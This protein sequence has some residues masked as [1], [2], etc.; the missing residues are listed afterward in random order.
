MG[1]SSPALKFRAMINR[2]VDSRWDNHF[3]KKPHAS[4]E[5]YLA[6]FEEAR[7][8][9]YPQIDELEAELG[10]AIDRLWL[11]ELAL[12]TQIVKKK[13][14]L[15]YPHGRLLYSLLRRMIAELGLDFV[16]ILE[17]GTA[18]GFSAVCMAKALEDAK[19]DGWIVTVDVLSHQRSQIWNCI[20]DHDGPKSRA[21]LLEP[22]SKLTRKIVFMQGDT[23]HLLP[24]IGMGRVHFA[25]LDNQ[26]TAES[27]MQEFGIVSSMQQSG[28]II[29]F[30]DVTPMVFPGV[31][32]AVDKIE[33]RKDYQV[34]RMTLSHQRAYAWA[35]R[36]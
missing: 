10:Y 18:R 21:S 11:D 3:G 32:A 9:Q 1:L 34:R 4:R 22:W 20:D 36:S 12:H 24:R 33:T 19:V 35:Q 29:V 27:V 6:L 16:S 25:F 2:W 7:L 26:H 17:T 14:E 30:D 5:D 31:V 8:K 15:A 23:L 13:S 28:D